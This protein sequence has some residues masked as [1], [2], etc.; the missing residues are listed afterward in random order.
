MNNFST[1]TVKH[2]KYIICRRFESEL[3]KHK[4]DM[5][6]SK[7]L[8]TNILELQ[9]VLCW[10]TMIKTWSL[11]LGLLKVCLFLKLESSDCRTYWTKSA[12]LDRS[13]IRLDRSNHVQIFFLQNSNSA[14]TL[15]KRIGFQVKHS[16]I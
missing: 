8:G 16:Y 11:G 4:S 5:L 9:F 1:W 2:F 7:I 14:Q 12:R 6:D 3:V 15:L 13:K 10:Q